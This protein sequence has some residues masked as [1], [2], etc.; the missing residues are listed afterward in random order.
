MQ[1]VH[2][3]REL[4]CL[5]NGSLIHDSSGE[6]SSLRCRALIQRATASQNIIS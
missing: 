1:W 6:G 3:I 5:S 2:E 4:E